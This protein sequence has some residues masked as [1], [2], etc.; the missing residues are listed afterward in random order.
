L[1]KLES[2]PG[3]RTD[4]PVERLSECLAQAG[5]FIA[6]QTADL[7]P[8][9]RLLYALRDETGTVPSI[10]LIVASI[11]SKKLAEGVQRLVLDVKYGSG[12]FMQSRPEA[13]LLA[14]ALAN[15]GQGAGLDVRTVL[16]PMD[17]PLGRAVG[18]AL[19]VAEAVACLQGGG[20][21]DL[22]DTVLA[23]AD[24]PAA[25]EMLA[26]GRAYARF[27]RMVRAQGGDPCAPLL[28]LAA[29]EEA[30][31]LAPHSGRFGGI[32]ALAA[33]RAAVAL[34]AGRQRAGEAVHPGVGLELLALPGED[35]QEGDP[36]V[37][38][39]HTGVGLGVAMALLESGLDWVNLGE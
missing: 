39:H 28:G 19:E 14:G 2:I 27:E 25:A 6:G 37:R 13:L 26:S 23:L 35:V 8:A 11:L 7:V 29:C 3:F 31:L 20:P 5:C 12:A 34:G 33:G 1:D 10:P 9:D 4:L 32:D 17:R 16:S 15:V 24:H 30:M 18:N 21:A 36:L 22:R 38:V